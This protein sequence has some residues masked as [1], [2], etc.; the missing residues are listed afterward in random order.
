M[1]LFIQY[2]RNDAIS[3]HGIAYRKLEAKLAELDT[4]LQER[5]LA[6]RWNREIPDNDE[7]ERVIEV[8]LIKA[9]DVVNPQLCLLLL[10]MIHLTTELANALSETVDS[11]LGILSPEVPIAQNNVICARKLIDSASATYYKVDL[12]RDEKY[13]IRASDSQIKRLFVEPPDT[14]RHFK[15]T[16]SAHGSGFIP[17]KNSIPMTHDEATKIANAW[18]SQ[19]CS[20]TGDAQIIDIREE[21]KETS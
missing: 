20:I 19:T 8:L 12:M 13:G 10:D 21:S 16:F 11:K 17:D 9:R 4:L 3:S 14:G 1:D 7:R 18:V 6:E 5:S 15:V 2:D